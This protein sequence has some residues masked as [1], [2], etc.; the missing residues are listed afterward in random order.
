MDTDDV[1]IT[2]VGQLWVQR[3]PRKWFGKPDKLQLPCLSLHWCGTLEL[4]T[5][6]SV[7][8]VGSHKLYD[9]WAP[10]CLTK[11]H[12]NLCFGFSLS[13]LQTLTDEWRNFLEWLVTDGGIWRHHFILRTRRTG[14]RWKNLS[15][16]RIRK[17]KICHSAGKFVIR[18]LERRENHQHWTTSRNVSGHNSQCEQRRAAM[19]AWGYSQEEARDIWGISGTWCDA[20]A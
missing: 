18:I 10:K 2:P 14:I 11:E 15:F 5:A 19:V 16:P 8:E 1:R 9:R 4:Y 17:F 13:H 6:L 3:E 12:I 7:G 20:L